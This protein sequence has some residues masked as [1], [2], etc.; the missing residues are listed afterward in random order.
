MMTV[1]SVMIVNASV[2][3]AVPQWGWQCL[4]G[5]GIASVGMAVPQWGWQRLSGDSS[6]PVGDDSASVFMAVPLV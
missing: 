4:S 2:G 5:G 1:P 3:M 6:A